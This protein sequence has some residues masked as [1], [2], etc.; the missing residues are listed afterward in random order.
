MLGLTLQTRHQR[1]VRARFRERAI[2]L[3][4]VVWRSA[5]QHITDTRASLAPPSLVRS[6]WSATTPSKISWLN[7]IVRNAR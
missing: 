3:D 1:I 5:D 6:D 2:Y 7:R 4:R